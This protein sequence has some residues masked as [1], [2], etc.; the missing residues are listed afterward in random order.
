MSQYTKYPSSGGT[1]KP[2]VANAAALPS[3]G[4]SLGDAR[5]AEDSGF[6]YVWNGSSWINN[7]GNGTVT[8]V[9]MTVPT[10]L[11]A[12]GGSPITGAGTLALS[13]QSQSANKVFASPDGSSGVPNFNI[14]YSSLSVASALV[15][16]DSSKNVVFG[17]STAGSATDAIKMGNM[18]IA[19]RASNANE[20]MIGRSAAVSAISFNLSSAGI[21]TADTD[22]SFHFEHTASE[23]QLNWR[24]NASYV[25]QIL[26]DTTHMN[27][28]TSGP[29]HSFQDGGGVGLTVSKMNNKMVLGMNQQFATDNTYSIGPAATL[30]TATIQDLRY[31]A[32]NPGGDAGNGQTVEY[33]DGGGMSDTATVNSTDGSKIIITINSGVTTA[34]TIKAA[35]EADNYANLYFTVTNAGTLA[36]TQTAPVSPVTLSGGV[37][38]RAKDLLLSRSLSIGNNPL[39]N[40]DLWDSS[41][42]VGATT[43]S[44]QVQLGSY[45]GDTSYLQFTSAD[46]AVWINMNETDNGL[47]FGYAGGTAPKYLF[48]GALGVNNSASATIAVGALANKIEIFDETGASLG[49][50]PV[51]SSIT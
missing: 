8:S 35:V 51:Y 28:Y 32:K 50:I 2:P 45:N 46:K 36:N 26:V 18:L 4:N 39:N 13:L 6:V 12:I 16:R 5:V 24:F 3:S 42:Q 9:A 49:F 25:G 41:I 47:M 37:S 30:A 34:S 40:L 17:T 48:D 20:L 27:Y 19:T 29:T 21:G 7:G 38:T 10:S 15:Q 1:W 14:G 31:T 23:V 33:V 43:A 22:Q 44:T 11:L